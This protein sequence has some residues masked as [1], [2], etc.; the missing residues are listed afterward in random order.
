MI[1]FKILIYDQFSRLF[2]VS[3]YYFC[4]IKSFLEYDLMILK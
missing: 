4:R 3:F 2:V 1:L